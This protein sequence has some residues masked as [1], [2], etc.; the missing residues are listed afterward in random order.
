M[1]A[2]QQALSDVRARLDRATRDLDAAR[3][4]MDVNDAA[5][6]ARFREM[7][8]GRDELFRR[9]SGPAVGDA[10]SAVERYNQ[11]SDEYNS[12][13]ANRPMDPGIVAKSQATLACPTPY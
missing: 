6:V 4:G 11:R 2:K 3:S 9:A 13:C 12:R 10:A 7:L 8:A 5:A 1:T